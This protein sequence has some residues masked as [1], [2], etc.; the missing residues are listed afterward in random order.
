MIPAATSLETL[1]PELLG[2]LDE[3]ISLLNKKY[4]ELEALAGAIVD[5][6]DERMENV[7]GEME[8]TAQDQA[9]TDIKLDALRN[10]FAGRLGWPQEETKLSRLTEALPEPQRMAID[11]RRQQIVL[12]A[13]RLR[14]RHMETAVLLMESAR[15]NRLLLAQLLPRNERVTTY[16][17]KGPGLW[18]ADTGL[19]DAEM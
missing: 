7:L 12:Q 4:D 15:I 16:S 9:A 19:L 10:V 1:I 3:E 18:R 8:S 14:Q 2:I 6:D 17:A 5:R 13:E 11:Y